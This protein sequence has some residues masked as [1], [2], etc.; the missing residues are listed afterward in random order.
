MLVDTVLL[1]LGGETEYTRT[2]ASTTPYRPRDGVLDLVRGAATIRVVAAHALGYAWLSWFGSMPLIFFVGGTLF[3]ASLDR[4]PADQMIPDR[5]RRLLLPLWLYAAV[6]LLVIAISQPSEI[7]GWPV[8]R[9]VSYFLPLQTPAGPDGRLSWLWVGLWF[10]R[11]YLW[12]VLLGAPL[13]WLFRR[14]PIVTLALPVAGLLLL[15]YGERWFG[16]APGWNGFLGDLTAYG[17]FWLLGYA[18]HDG[19]FTRLALRR[20]LEVLAVTTA[21]AATA[22]AAIPP[23]RGDVSADALLQV[24][25]GLAWVALVVAADAPLHAAVRR[26]PVA[27][28]VRFLGLR[29][30]TIYLG[31]FIAL[32]TVEWLLVHSIVPTVSDNWTLSVVVYTVP[33]LALYVV[34]AGWLEDIAAGRPP[35]VWPGVRLPS[36]PRV[37]PA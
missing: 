24:L 13:R 21:V 37:A 14:V 30:Y 33:A 36:R 7:S 9:A 15:L 8:H 22:R 5:L 26:A 1:A 35:Q 12:F 25:V 10:V 20:R 17:I 27:A 32:L 19:W 34:L 2:V 31:Q 18:H 6:S 23:P 11:A 16:W 4:R 29:A 3:A 28:A